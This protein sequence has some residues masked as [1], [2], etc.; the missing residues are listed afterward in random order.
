MSDFEKPRRALPDELSCEEKQRRPERPARIAFEDVAAG[1][2]ALRLQNL[3]PLE[4]A[5]PGDEQVFA[6]RCPGAANAVIELGSLASLPTVT[7]VV[8]STEVRARTPLPAIR[9]LLLVNVLPARLPDAATLANLPNLE[10]L[11]ALHAAPDRR[12]DPAL[13][14]TT[15]AAL[16]VGRHL[17]VGRSQRDPVWRLAPLERLQ[18]LVLKSCFPTDSVAP[19]ASMPLLRSLTTDAP[20]GWSKLAGLEGLEEVAAEGPRVANLRSIGNWRRLRRL[21]LSGGPLASIDGIEHLESLESLDLRFIRIDDLTA[22]AGL[23][24]L[25]ALRLKCLPHLRDL[26]PVGTLPGLREL[27]IDGAHERQWRMHLGSLSA[28]RS[29]SSLERLSISYTT[30]DDGDLSPL[31]ELPNLRF[32]ELPAELGEQARRLREARSD[33]DIV[34]QSGSQ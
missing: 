18:A 28:L 16:G 8:A 33:L 11:W 12:L 2:D 15:M 23:P 20:G 30:V 3:V 32:V 6:A 14:P 9:E 31:L 22:L 25:T 5:L 24:N 29:A 1:G 7:S 13:L 26:G 4:A 34:M 10:A 17:L 19:L 21:W 27:A